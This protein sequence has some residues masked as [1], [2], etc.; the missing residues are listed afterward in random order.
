MLADCYCMLPLWEWGLMAAL[1]RRQTAAAMIDRCEKS[2]RAE[3][4]STCS[5]SAFCAYTTA[6]HHA[7]MMSPI[8]RREEARRRLRSRLP[9]SVGTCSLANLPIK[10][11]HHNNPQRLSTRHD[12]NGRQRPPWC[13]TPGSATYS[14]CPECW[15]IVVCGGAGREAPWRPWD[16]GGRHGR[17]DTA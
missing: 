16:D 3:K 13:P 15:L 14:S 4:L 17:R 7:A 9:W 10:N 2:H 12:L 5:Y 1:G 11:T 6:T 8:G